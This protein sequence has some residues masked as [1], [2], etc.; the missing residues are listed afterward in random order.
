MCKSNLVILQ[1]C[2]Q[3]GI[4]LCGALTAAG[5]MAAHGS[6]PSSK[7]YGVV[8]LIDCRSSLDPPL[9]LHNFGNLSTLL[10]YTLISIYACRVSNTI[11]IHK[12]C[13]LSS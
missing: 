8:T 6:K 2:K 12:Y 9:S 4:K 5:L 1:G 11:N 7:K 3:K 13:T 10:L